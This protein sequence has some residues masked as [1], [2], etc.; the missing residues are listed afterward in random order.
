MVAETYIPNLENKPQVN[1]I[2]GIKNDNR[3]INLEWVTHQENI[4]HKTKIL[5][6]GIKESHPSVKL[7]ENNIQWIRN[8]YIPYDKEYGMNGLSKKFNTSASNIH[9]IIHKKTWI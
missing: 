9:K 7:N 4:L 5:K 6:K 8:N 3:V 2:N 1:H